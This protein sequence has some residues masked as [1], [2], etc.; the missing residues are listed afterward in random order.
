MWTPRY[1]RQMSYCIERFIPTPYACP[2][3]L[4][5]GTGDGR[6]PRSDG[7]GYRVQQLI[8]ADGVVATT[9]GSS[10]LGLFGIPSIQGTVTGCSRA[11]DPSLI[12]VSCTAL[13]GFGLLPPIRTTV[14]IVE[15]GGR[16]AVVAFGTLY[17]SLEV[18]RYGAGR[19]QLVYFYDASPVEIRAGLEQYGALRNVAPK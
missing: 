15:T 7:G 9:P 8:T 4:P 16:P 14:W 12:A 2:F 11:S 19:P 6:G 18:W 10:G 3:P 17:P 1:Q 5:C 13:N